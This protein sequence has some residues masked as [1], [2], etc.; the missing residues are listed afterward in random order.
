MSKHCCSDSSDKNQTKKQT[1]QNIDYQKNP[2]LVNVTRGGI[3]ESSHNGRICVVDIQGN[4]QLAMGE[5][6]KPIYPRSSVKI[7]LALPMA[8]SGA[9][10]K[11]N[12]NAEELSVICSS[13]TG[14]ERHTQ[15][16][17]NI[18]KK[19]NLSENDLECGIHTPINK[20]QSYELVKQGIKPNQLHN[21]CSGKHAGMLLLAKMRN[22]DTAGYINPN[23]PVQQS[24]MGIFEMM[25]EY[26]LQDAPSD[27][28]G[29]SVP[30]WAIPMTNLA[31]AF[32]KIS[33][34][35]AVLPN[36]TAKA[37]TKLRDSVIQEPFMVGGT[38]RCCTKIMQVLKH[39]AFVKYGA[40]AVYMASL[41]EYGLGIAIKIDDG[42]TRAVEVA[43]LRILDKIGVLSDKDKQQL[44][45]LY[46]QPIINCNGFTVGNVE[47]AF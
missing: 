4:I 10:E 7:L 1:E 8:L 38:N 5:V 35:F 3:I 11:Y 31:F 6:E 33:D 19:A 15:V 26:S 13:H 16:V 36:E 25:Y 32:A 44:A 17:K 23:H 18:L 20:K 43:L 41:P 47:P 42:S 12:L 37:I 2:T 29:C 27:R 30:T 28:D 46:K 40:E 39:K 24:I 14:E 22:F 21:N 34:P 9:I 45:D